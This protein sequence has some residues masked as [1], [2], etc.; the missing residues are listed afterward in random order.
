M[1]TYTYKRKDGSKFE[2]PQ[3][4]TEDALT[5]CPTTGQPVSRV[6]TGGSGLVFKG[7]GFYQTDYVKKT[8]APE[9]GKG[10][11]GAKKDEA[12]S[13]ATPKGEKKESK[14]ETKTKAATD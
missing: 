4:I 8:G 10:K 1:P 2:I 9:G 7:T 5:T 6:I 3:K 13:K 11:S 12:P 14:K